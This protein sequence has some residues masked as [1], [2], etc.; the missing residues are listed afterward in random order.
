MEDIEKLIETLA[1]CVPQLDRLRN[2]TFRTAIAM[3]RST[4][5]RRPSITLWPP[6]KARA[7]G[8]VTAAAW[9]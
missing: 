1:L 8:A 5:L 9:A 2:R 7:T 6:G 4:T 3:P